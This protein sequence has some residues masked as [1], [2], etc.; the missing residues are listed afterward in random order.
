MIYCCHTEVKQRGAQ[1]SPQLRETARG[2]SVFVQDT[3]P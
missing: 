3:A 2:L 1:A